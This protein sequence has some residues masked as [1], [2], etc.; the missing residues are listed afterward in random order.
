LQRKGKR[1]DKE[2]VKVCLTLFF[3]GN[4]KDSSRKRLRPTAP[5]ARAE[6]KN[7]SRRHSDMLDVAKNGFL[8][9]GH[10]KSRKHPLQSL[11]NI[12]PL[13]I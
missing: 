5:W 3:V 1:G 8:N 6:K 7:Q 9:F 13:I 11:Q 4:M 2:Q 12:I 10:I